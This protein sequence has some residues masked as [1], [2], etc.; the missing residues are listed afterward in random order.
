MTIQNYPWSRHG[1]PRS[2]G[3]VRKCVPS[4]QGYIPCRAVEH[5]PKLARKI[6]PP[7]FDGNLPSPCSIGIFKPSPHVWHE[8]SSPMFEGDIHP[9]RKL[10]HPCSTGIFIPVESL[11][12]MFDGDIYPR[13]KL[14]QDIY[15]VDSPYPSTVNAERSPQKERSGINIPDHP[16]VRSSPRVRTG[17][18]K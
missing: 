17:I 3:A 14:S 9:R 13:R 4:R 2:T 18:K 1:S 10:S 15:P 11:S 12:S 6:H 8:Y 7:R 16:R 5:V